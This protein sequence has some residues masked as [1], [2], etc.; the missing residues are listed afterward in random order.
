MI[1]FSDKGIYTLMCNIY[2]IKKIKRKKIKVVHNSI[3][4]ERF[5]GSLFFYAC[6][7]VHICVFLHI[8]IH[9]VCE[10]CIFPLPL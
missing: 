10:T 9:V 2:K 5:T 8:I 7:Y 4:T 6:E 3:E 1:T